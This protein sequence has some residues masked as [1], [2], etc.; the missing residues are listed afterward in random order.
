M[1]ITKRRLE[2]NLR[3]EEKIGE[4]GTSKGQARGED[5]DVLV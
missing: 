2:R 5:G 3:G 1:C 4:G